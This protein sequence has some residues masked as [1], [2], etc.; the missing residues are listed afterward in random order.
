MVTIIEVLDE[1]EGPFRAWVEGYAGGE[2]WSLVRDN[3]AN[4][5]DALLWGRN[6]AEAQKTDHALGTGVC[7]SSGPVA[8]LMVET[9]RE[10][11]K[12]AGPE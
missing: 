8:I 3:I 7:V 6:L 10:P 11:P 2:G 12:P 5:A 9:I 1:C 4:R